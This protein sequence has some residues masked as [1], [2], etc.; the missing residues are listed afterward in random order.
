[1]TENSLE[2]VGAGH[3]G[4]LAQS[5]TDGEAYRLARQ[6]NIPMK[7]VKFLEKQ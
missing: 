4:S 2:T 7:K 5:G 1:M 6:Q 3:V